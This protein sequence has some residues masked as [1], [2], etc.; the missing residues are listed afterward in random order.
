MR[1]LGVLAYLALVLVVGGAV[2]CV[3][4]AYRVLV[5]QAPGPKPVLD[6]LL[7]LWYTS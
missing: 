1:P 4:A 6:K 7:S 2:G 5:D 3:E